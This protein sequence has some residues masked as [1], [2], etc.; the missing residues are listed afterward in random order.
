[1][2]NLTLDCALCRDS[3]LPPGRFYNVESGT[4]QRCACWPERTA[5][6]AVSKANIA[7]EYREASFDEIDLD[8]KY[9]NQ[10]EVVDLCRAYAHE[11]P[12]VKIEGR[13][14]AIFGRKSS[15]G[16]S[17]LASA[18]CNH[19]IKNYWTDSVDGQDVCLFL[20]VQQWFEGW[21]HHLNK[22]PWSEHGSE[23]DRAG[24]PN[25]WRER[26]ALNVLDERARTTELLVLDDMAKFNVGDRRNLEKLYGVVEHRAS[27]GLP[28]VATEN[29]EA[30]EEIAVRLGP[31]FGPPIVDRIARNGHMAV[32]QEAMAR[33]KKK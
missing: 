5:I 4:V 21:R 25:F 32:I 30:W 3:D 6:L 33:K 2:A 28:M 8:P 16:K 19:L 7:S 1:M 29:A 15:M 20:N 13:S 14:L 26:K 9:P 24:D 23:H 18:I 11:W 22:Y 27:N 12:R 10:A 17:L 31:D